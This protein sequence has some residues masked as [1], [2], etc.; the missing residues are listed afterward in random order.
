VVTINLDELGG[1][2][3]KIVDMFISNQDIVDLMLPNPVVGYDIDVQLFGDGKVDGMFEGQLFPYFYTDGTNEK[4]RTFVLVETDAPE[5]YKD[6]IFKNINLYI[7]EFTHKSLVNLSGL[8]K[9]KYIQKGY[10][11]TCRTDILA[12]AIDNILNKN[13]T[14]GLGIK[15]KNVKIFKPAT[16][17]YYGRV[18]QYTVLCE[19]TGGDICGY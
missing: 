10:L 3:Q 15:L 17:D 8:E 18:L 11:G 7:Y 14:F 16:N 19:N 5:V 9:L 12:T 2:K 4:A 13:E 1:Y 6:G